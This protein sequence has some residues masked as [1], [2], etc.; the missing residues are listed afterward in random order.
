MARSTSWNFFKGESSGSFETLWRS[1]TL[2][3]GQNI[4]NVWPAVGHPEFHEAKAQKI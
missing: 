3:L 1:L 4:C 2:C